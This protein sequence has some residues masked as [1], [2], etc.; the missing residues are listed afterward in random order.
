M[1]LLEIEVF[2]SVSSFL[3]G[4]QNAGSRQGTG[5]FSVWFFF[6]HSLKNFAEL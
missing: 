1:Q 6:L 2:Y 4:D 3:I 5:S